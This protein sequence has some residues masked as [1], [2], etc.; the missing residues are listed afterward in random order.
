MNYSF[1][2]Q[3]IA[4]FELGRE[5]TQLLE[6]GSDPLKPRDIVV[7]IAPYGYTPVLVSDREYRSIDEVESVV[8]EN[9][10]D[11][12]QKKFLPSFFAL[13]FHV[14]FDGYS[15]DPLPALLIA[16]VFPFRPNALSEHQVVSV[17]DDL[18]HRVQVIVHPPKVLHL[19]LLLFRVLLQSR[20]RTLHAKC[21]RFIYSSDHASSYL[22]AISCRRTRMSI[23]FVI[24]FDVLFLTQSAT[25]VCSN[26][27]SLE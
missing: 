13:L 16:W 3:L 18:A 23:Y 7:V 19:P 10:T 1:L 11:H 20:M 8:W 25:H 22:C 24:F 27:Y 2:V 21:T 14:L 26:W 5:L 4:E 17:R 15:D 9:T 12:V 6:S